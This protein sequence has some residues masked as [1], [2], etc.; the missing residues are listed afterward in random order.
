[1]D[2]SSDPST[3]ARAATGSPPQ[4]DRLQGRKR[5]RLHRHHGNPC[6]GHRLQRKVHQKSNTGS[7]T[8]RG[9]HSPREPG[10]EK[11]HGPTSQKRP[12]ALP[13]FG[14]RVPGFNPY[15]TPTSVRKSE[16]GG[17]RRT[18]TSVTESDITRSKQETERE[19]YINISL[20]S[21]SDSGSSDRESEV[22]NQRHE[23]ERIRAL[24]VQNWPLLEQT[25][26]R[27]LDSAIRH[28]QTHG[29]TYLQ[30][31][32]RVK[33]ENLQKADQAARTCVHCRTVRDTSDEV[34]ACVQCEDPIC[35]DDR[36]ICRQSTCFR[37][38]GAGSPD[39]NRGPADQLRR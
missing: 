27:F 16:V 14:H 25:G 28:Y 23:Q 19:E 34:K 4:R 32:L 7:G 30:R 11:N 24:V 31:D 5:H 3:Q 18:R 38:Q 33:W 2:Q 10:P 13:N 37:K 1:M 21:G 6:P 26:W 39:R 29:I 36:S 15:R 12:T 8:E 17:T 20:T 22:T 9:S 35:V